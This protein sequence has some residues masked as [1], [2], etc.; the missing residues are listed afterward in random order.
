VVEGIAFVDIF[1]SLE[2]H[3]GQTDAQVRIQTLFLLGEE[4]GLSVLLVARV[5]NCQSGKG[6]F[7]E[8]HIKIANIGI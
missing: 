6:G 5:M 4:H 7:R 2:E 3:F 1:E 8:K